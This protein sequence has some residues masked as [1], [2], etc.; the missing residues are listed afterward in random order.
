[1]FKLVAGF[2]FHGEQSVVLT[3]GSLVSMLLSRAGLTSDWWLLGYFI[4]NA[5]PSFQGFFFLKW[6]LFPHLFLCPF[7]PH[8]LFILHMTRTCLNSAF[9][10]FSNLEMSVTTSISLYLVCNLNYPKGWL[11][12]IDCWYHPFWRPQWLHQARIGLAVVLSVWSNE[13]VG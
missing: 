6:N 3:S 1:M 5:S 12:L 8:T 9:A 2:V 10:R 7:P 13:L 11:F 4:I